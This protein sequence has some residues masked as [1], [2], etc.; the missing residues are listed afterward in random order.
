MVVGW[1]AKLLDLRLVGVNEGLTG[2]C[3][4]ALNARLACQSR[5]PRKWLVLS[6]I[7]VFI[8]VLSKKGFRMQSAAKTTGRSRVAAL[9]VT[10]CK[11]FTA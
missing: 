7:V 8:R 3:Y 1:E 9:A 10:Y 2:A 4:K 5:R 6:C 11:L